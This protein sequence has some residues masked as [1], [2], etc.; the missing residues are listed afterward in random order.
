MEHTKLI[1]LQ[2]SLRKSAIFFAHHEGESD[3]QDPEMLR[4]YT[5]IAILNLC[6][7]AAIKNFRLLSSE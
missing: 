7:V 4:K 3:A 2:V 6:S 1:N 5:I